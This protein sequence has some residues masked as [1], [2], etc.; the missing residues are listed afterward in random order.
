[1]DP[2]DA[3][4][5]EGD[6]STLVSKAAVVVSLGSSQAVPR[7]RAKGSV[8]RPQRRSGQFLSATVLQLGPHQLPRLLMAVP[9]KLVPS[10]P[11]RNLI[12][13]VLREAWRAYQA[14]SA[15]APGRVSVRLQ[16]HALPCDPTLA[17]RDERGQLRRAFARR[18]PDGAL[19]RLIRADAQTLLSQS[20]R[21]TGAHQP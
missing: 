10:S 20:V 1:M 3:A 9:K 12:R 19:K 5:S 2:R 7:A 16:M 15:V 14:N 6:R 21:S 13:R 4:L 17:E 8:R 18:P 11:V